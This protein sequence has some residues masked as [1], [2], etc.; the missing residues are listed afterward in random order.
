MP[1]L[2]IPGQ[3]GVNNAFR[4]ADISPTLN[5]ERLLRQPSGLP[6]FLRAGISRQCA[7]YAA[8]TKTPPCQIRGR[9]YISDL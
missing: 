3:A 9:F 5:P 4:A 6:L 7:L 8:Q 2:A 1:L